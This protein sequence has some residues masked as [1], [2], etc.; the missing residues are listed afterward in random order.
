LY[1]RPAPQ[2]GG[3]HAWYCEPD[4]EPM[5]DEVID[6]RLLPFLNGQNKLPSQTCISIPIVNFT[7]LSDLIR[8]L[9]FA[10]NDG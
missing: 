7:W 1:L 3:T 6:L 5:A 2:D 10:V 8:D 4:Q 9:P